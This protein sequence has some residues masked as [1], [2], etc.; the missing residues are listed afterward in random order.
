MVEKKRFQERK[1]RMDLRRKRQT[2]GPRVEIWVMPD[3]TS[4]QDEVN[5]EE[6]E[7]D[8]SSLSAVEVSRGIK[9]CLVVDA[10]SLVLFSLLLLDE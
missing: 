2:Q 9:V 6:E 4:T 7:E 5:E 1:Q 3:G 8:L 10:D